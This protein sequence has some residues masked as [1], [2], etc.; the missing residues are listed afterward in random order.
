MRL[1][2]RMGV[3]EAHML[4][5]QALF[6]CHQQGKPGDINFDQH[7]DVDDVELHDSS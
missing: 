5:L 3:E 2:E 1:A 4:G 6:P 7:L